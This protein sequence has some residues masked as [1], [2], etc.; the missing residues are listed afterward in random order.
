MGKV[1]FIFFASVLLFWSCN[2]SVEPNLKEENTNELNDQMVFHYNGILDTILIIAE[3]NGYNQNEVVIRGSGLMLENTIM[4]TFKLINQGKTAINDSMTGY[5]DLG[6][7]IPFNK[8]L[9]TK[10]AD[11]YIEIDSYDKNTNIIQG[12]INL[13]FRFEDDTTKVVTFSE[14]EFRAKIDTRYGFTYC[15][16]G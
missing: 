16:E 10:E 4:L 6:L 8:Y 5:W 1:I 11:N 14:G 12:K 9:L 3:K 13:T 15:F 7:C 2:K